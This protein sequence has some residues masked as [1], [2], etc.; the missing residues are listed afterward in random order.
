MKLSKERDNL[1]ITAKKLGRDLAKVNAFLQL[2]LFFILLLL[3]SRD[4]LS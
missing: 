1:A 4:T 2:L 3:N